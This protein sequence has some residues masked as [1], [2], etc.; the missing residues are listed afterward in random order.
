[1]L[2]LSQFIISIITFSKSAICCL[3]VYGSIKRIFSII[4][5]A[6]IKESVLFQFR[7]QLYPIT[8]IIEHDIYEI[9]K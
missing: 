7:L 3:L 9:N 8:S 5:Y 2:L 4:V 6:T 1:M